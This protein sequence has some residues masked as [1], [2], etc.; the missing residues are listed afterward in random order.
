M[1]IDAHLFH[2]IVNVSLALSLWLS[3]FLLEPS[4]ITH[5]QTPAEIGEWGPILDWGIQ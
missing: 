5:A 1:R 4:A 2:R 3:L